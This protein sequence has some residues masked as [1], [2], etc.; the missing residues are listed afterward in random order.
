MDEAAVAMIPFHPLADIFPLIEG[1]DF[2]ALTAD[3]RVHGLREPI[4]LLEKQI[5]DGRNRYRASVAAG[6]IPGDRDAPG[7]AHLKHFHWFAPPGSTPTQAELVAFVISK[8][9]RRRQ[10]NESQR[11]QVAAKLATLSH[12]G[13]R[14]KA[15]IGALTDAQAATMLHVSERSV[16]RA[17]AV[18]REGASELQRKVE[19]GELRISTAAMIA[20]LPK[21]EQ[22]KLLREAAPAA[23]KAAAKEIRAEQQAEKKDRRDTREKILG[24]IQMALPDKKY[25][26]ILADPEWRFEVYSRDS[27]MDRAADNHY[28]TSATDEICARAVAEIAATDC[29]LFLW[30][31]APMLPD[32]LR[33][34][35]A[36]GFDYKSH[37]IWFKDRIGTGY[38]FRNQHELLLVGTRGNVPAPSM[39][40]QFT[41]VNQAA[42]GEHSEKPESF[43]TMI[44]SY[45]PT[46][47]KIELNARRARAGW[48]SWGFEAP[49]AEDEAA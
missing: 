25:G 20:R 16:E 42:V 45:F 5:L 19:T 11:A 46:L 30:A 18:Q 9:L 34:M 40:S 17:K 27:G 4:V 31:T 22:V 47:P 32:A 38:W 2:D 24:G 8:N 6:I 7:P 14:S 26:A 1:E 41:S 37:A 29:V 33:V 28:P 3:I 44:E 21:D 23:V 10:L 49:N 39:G 15:P 48:D 13:D 35:A 12:G 36:W 43:Y